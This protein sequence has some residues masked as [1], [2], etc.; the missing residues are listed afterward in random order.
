MRFEP[1]LVVQSLPK[2][3]VH[4]AKCERGVCRRARLDVLIGG[5]RGKRA[6]RI[7]DNDI[8]AVV[9]CL[10]EDWHEMWAGAGG[11]V[12]PD[13]DEPAVDE[14]SGIRSQ[15]RAVGRPD[16]HLGGGSADRAL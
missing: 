15:T 7:D 1:R 10:P 3:D 14:V 16:G 12:A 5:T 4:Q 13:D 6:A 8:C 2:E 9:L 11:I